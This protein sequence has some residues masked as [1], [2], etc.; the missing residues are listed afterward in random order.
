MSA[1]DEIS[2]LVDEVVSEK[3]SVSDTEREEPPPPPVASLAKRGRPV[4]KTDS[5]QRKRRTAAEIS[6]DKNQSRP[7]ES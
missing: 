2:S 6:E 3:E 5:S 1:S 4:G 7:N